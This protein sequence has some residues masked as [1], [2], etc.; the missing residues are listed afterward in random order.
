MGE[1]CFWRKN[2]KD[3]MSGAF[4]VGIDK[5]QQT[6]VNMECLERIRTD[7]MNVSVT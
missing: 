1:F 5:A 3:N 2:L 4:K 6:K 7:R